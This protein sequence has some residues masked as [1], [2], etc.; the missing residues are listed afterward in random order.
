[1]S[2]QLKLYP[3]HVRI[4]EI[5]LKATTALSYSEIAKDAKMLPESTLFHLDLLEDQGL[6]ISHFGKAHPEEPTTIQRCYEPT[7]KLKTAVHQFG[8]SLTAL[9]K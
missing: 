3:G 8:A 9:S 7:E 4:V 1:M 6:V 2:E 5:L